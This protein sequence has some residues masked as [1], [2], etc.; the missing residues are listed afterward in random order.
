M[1]AN[2][3]AEDEDFE[4]EEEIDRLYGVPHQMEAGH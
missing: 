3:T 1:A 4:E 2:G